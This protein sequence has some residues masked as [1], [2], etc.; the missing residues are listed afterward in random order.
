V[1]T[2]A[3]AWSQWLRVAER[4]SN[5]GEVDRDEA[6]VVEST[7]SVNVRPLSWS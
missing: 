3:N 6:P 5:A 4:V 7:S 1:L 2:H